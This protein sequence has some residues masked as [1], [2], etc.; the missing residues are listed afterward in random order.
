MQP[1][2][3]TSRIGAIS[4]QSPCPHRTFTIGV[5]GVEYS[6]ASLPE[7]DMSEAKAITVLAICGS[8]RQGSYNKAALRT[9]IEE[10]PPGMTI[11]SADIGSIPLY[12]QNVP[13]PHLPPP[14]R[15]PPPPNPPPPPPP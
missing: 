12:K 13:P 9:A 1:R 2:S 8:L 3:G 7:R 15:P 5:A 11:E 14:P 10:K 4:G 6:S